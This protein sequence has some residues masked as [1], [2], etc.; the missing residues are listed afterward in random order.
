MEI[1]L[2]AGIAVIIVLAGLVVLLNPIRNKAKQGRK[3]SEQREAALGET[4]RRRDSLFRAQRR[5]AHAVK[6]KGYTECWEQ[7]INDTDFHTE[8]ASKAE[9]ARQKY[10]DK[11]HACP[12][13]GTRAHKLAWFY[14]T[15]APSSWQALA[16]RGGWMT[17]CRQCNVQ[18]DFFPE[19]L[20]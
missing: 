6:E 8:S 20:N 15:S 13:C 16:G 1:N 5:E 17:A 2:I 14:I 18:V 11:A 19:L 3:M 7:A 10:G 12:K 4:E 9:A